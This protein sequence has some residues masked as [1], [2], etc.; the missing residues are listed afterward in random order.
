MANKPLARSN[1]QWIAGVC[2]GLA[3]YFSWDR[4]MVRLIYL[5]LTVC[6]VAFPGVLIYLILWVLMP[7]EV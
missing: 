7:R 3:D 4:S 2:A 1:D 5:F 6:T